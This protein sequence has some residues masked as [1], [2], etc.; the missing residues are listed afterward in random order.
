MKK[1]F[2]LLFVLFAICPVISGQ[3]MREQITQAVKAGVKDNQEAKPDELNANSDVNRL[4]NVIFFR[5]DIVTEGGA[6]LT[7]D[8]KECVA[9]VIDKA[10]AIASKKCRLSKGEKVSPAAG[11]VDSAYSSNFRIILNNRSYKVAHYETKNLFILRAIDENGNPLFK[12]NPQVNL[13]YTWEKALPEDFREGAFEVNRTDKHSAKKDDG[14]HNSWEDNFHPYYGV[15]RRTFPKEINSFRY[16]KKIQSVFATISA[17]LIYGKEVRAGDPLFYIE[18]GKKYLFG[19][20]NATNL[21]DNFPH[22]RTDK[23][24]VFTFS[25]IKEMTEKIQPIDRDVALRIRQNMLFK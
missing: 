17:S 9:V 15:A 6:S 8:N 24:L 12:D 20:A 7:N 25:D 23:V 22:T 4:V 3:E 14:S 13:A 21:W 16:D 18:R 5:Q 2:T 19:F 10:W 1:L 11:T